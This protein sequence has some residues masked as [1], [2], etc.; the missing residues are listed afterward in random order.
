[1]AKETLNP[2]H[3]RLHTC[4][5]EVGVVKYNNIVHT[6]SFV[7]YIIMF[8]RDLLHKDVPLWPVSCSRVQSSLVGGGW[9]HCV[10]ADSLC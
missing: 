4:T 7:I 3:L 10:Y 6:K 5:K 9:F 8:T 1:M 2:N